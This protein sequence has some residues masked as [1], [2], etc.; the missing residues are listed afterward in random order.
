MQAALRH[1]WL[2][3]RNRHYVL[4]GVPFLVTLFY[5]SGHGGGV[6]GGGSASRTTGWSSHATSYALRRLAIHE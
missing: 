6:Q 5:L 2:V 3:S 4:S 1:D